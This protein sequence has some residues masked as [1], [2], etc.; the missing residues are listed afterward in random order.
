MNAGTP[1]PDG[2]L[3]QSRSHDLPP[4]WN[5]HRVQWGTWA[6][7]TTVIRI[8]PHTCP[9]GATEPH[10]ATL[11]R[12]LSEQYSRLVA[13][14]CSCGRDQVTELTGGH[15]RTVSLTPPDYTDTG[16]HDNDT[17]D[18]DELEAGGDLQ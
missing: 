4:R 6:D 5:G 2:G 17:H 15:T 11:G 12:V 16:H 9:C 10:Q 14:R 18:N 8:H 3:Y 13:T 1:V 7:A